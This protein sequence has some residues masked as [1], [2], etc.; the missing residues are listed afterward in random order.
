MIWLIL[1]EAP[2]SKN[3][4]SVSITITSQL[5]F[6]FVANVYPKAQEKATNSESLIFSNSRKALD[7]TPIA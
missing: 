4:P 2:E 6:P 1:T 3:P 7:F 5:T